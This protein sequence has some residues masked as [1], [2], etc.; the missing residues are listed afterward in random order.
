MCLLRGFCRRRQQKTQSQYHESSPVTNGTTS[1][2]TP[3]LTPGDL[4]P[5]YSVSPGSVNLD[6]SVAFDN[7][8]YGALPQP[9]PEGATT[10]TDTDTGVGVQVVTTP[11]QTACENP[12]FGVKDK[13]TI[14]KKLLLDDVGAPLPDTTA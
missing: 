10:D 5:S 4:S 14:D 6:G 9:R 13:G 7:P 3:G 2:D 11:G 8:V 1:Y 12:L